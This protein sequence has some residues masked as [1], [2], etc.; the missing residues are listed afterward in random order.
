M[1]KIHNLAVTK[2]KKQQENDTAIPKNEKTTSHNYDEQ[3]T[4]NRKSKFKFLGKTFFRGKGV[5]SRAVASSEETPNGED[6][7]HE[8]DASCMPAGNNSTQ[9]TTKTIEIQCS[10]GGDT[11]QE[12]S[13][14]TDDK[15]EIQSDYVE[16]TSFVP[17]QANG[18]AGGDQINIPTSSVSTFSNIVSSRFDESAVSTNLTQL[19]VNANN[20]R[21]YENESNPI[22][23]QLPSQ[24]GT[25]VM[26]DSPNESQ[27]DSGRI[28]EYPA[29]V[30]V[31]VSPAVDHNFHNSPLNLTVPRS[32][33]RNTLTNEF[34]NLA[35][36]G[37][38]WGPLSR[39]EA[40]DKLND[41]PNGSFLVRDSSDERYLLSLSFR[42]FGRTL[43]TRIEH[44]TGRFSFYENN[45]M[46]SYDSV[47]ELI[48]DSVRDSQD[49][50]IFCYSRTR[51]PL[52]T[53]Y[54]V[55]LIFPV[56]R[57]SQVRTLQYLCRFVIRQYTRIDHIESLP[58][59]NPVKGYL[60]ECYF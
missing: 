8:S 34:K 16:N 11:R 15:N 44:S 47:V 31:P 4:N 55:R 1:K 41:T 38:Y 40:E 19:S 28:Q 59:P 5:K 21:T 56:S 32:N 49:A 17:H 25:H 45:R 10:L 24:N 37:W 27:S 35:Q 14:Q 22:V 7:Y 18:Y 39:T 2:R 29:D 12:K 57:L 36:Q 58:L 6:T 33:K 52:A 3:L 48:T 46:Q 9:D 20:N 26:P 50:G 43:H 30:E 60:N 53:T 42:S 51:D 23:D 13:C 54:P